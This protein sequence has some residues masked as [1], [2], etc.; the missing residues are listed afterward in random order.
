[1]IQLGNIYQLV[2]FDFLKMGHRTGKISNQVLQIVM[3][4][5]YLKRFQ[6]QPTF[7]RGLYHEF[8]DRWGLIPN[9]V[10]KWLKASGTSLKAMNQGGDFHLPHALRPVT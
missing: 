4:P 3:G 5:V 2:E 6:H 8:F 7:T 1:M 10:F 9:P